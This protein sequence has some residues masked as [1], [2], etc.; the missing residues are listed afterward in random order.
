[1]TDDELTALFEN[2]ARYVRNKFY[3]PSMC[4][5]IESRYRSPQTWHPPEARPPEVDQISG[6][7]VEKEVSY[8]QRSENKSFKGYAEIL[9]GHY[10]FKAKPEAT[11][12]RAVIRVRD[13]NAVLRVAQLTVKNRMKA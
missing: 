8:L 12:R 5:S 6:M 1:M 4:Q 9:K 2:W 13:Y 7:A 3:E 11:C 10:V